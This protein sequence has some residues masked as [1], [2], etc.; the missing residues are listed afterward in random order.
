VNAR[1][2][3]C[4][5]LLII[6][7]AL[8]ACGARRLELPSGAGQPFPDFSQAAQEA[9]A[10]CRGVKTISAELGIS[11]RAGDQKLRGR[12]TAGIAPASMRLEGTAPFG[13]PVFILAADGARA[14]LLLP[15]D[16]RIVVDETPAAIL[17]ALV[18]LDLGPADLLALLSGCVVPDPTPVGGR[19]FPRGWAR[20]DLAGDT[21]LFLQR[22]PRQRWQVRSGS[23]QRLGVEYETDAGGAVAAVRV[24]VGGDAPRTTDLRIV[25]SQVERDVPLSPDVFHLKIP[26][27]A[28]PLSLTELRQ[29]GPM[30]KK[31]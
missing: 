6:S 5:G 1:L 13:P 2:A 8:S 19:L 31:R 25:L 17:D 21:A 14:T 18:G 30:G 7:A 9:T 11:G 10:S 23:R 28:L 22:D 27:D 3:A 29:S 15:R 26:A 4:A 16:N 12:A 24:T 20:I